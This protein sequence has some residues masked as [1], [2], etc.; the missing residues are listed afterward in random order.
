M[1]RRPPSRDAADAGGVARELDAAR[2]ELLLE[3]DLDR[4]TG[5]GSE[6][7]E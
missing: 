2:F 1:R 7:E 5:I 3:P 6:A 4:D